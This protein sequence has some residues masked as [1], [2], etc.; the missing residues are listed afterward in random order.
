MPSVT[1]SKSTIHTIGNRH[2]R[3]EADGN[4]STLQATCSCGWAGGKV[5][6]YNDDQIR[7]VNQDAKTHLNAMDGRLPL[8]PF[9][10]RVIKS[11]STDYFLI[12]EGQE[13]QDR[14]EYRKAVAVQDEPRML[15][16]EEGRTGWQLLDPVPW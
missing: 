1:D 5:A 16:F 14:E 15:H 6:A 3:N 9:H 11:Y 7:Q 13:Q 4:L 8:S 12:P 10:P 2:E